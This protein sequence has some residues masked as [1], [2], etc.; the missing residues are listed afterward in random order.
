[1]ESSYAWL[2]NATRG[3]NTILGGTMGG[4]VNVL[5]AMMLI[6]HQRERNELGE[7]PVVWFRDSHPEDNKQRVEAKLSTR[8]H[9]ATGTSNI[10]YLLVSY[11]KSTMV[12]Q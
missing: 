1:M 5:Q 9:A 11:Q 3:M 7:I 4:Y 10:K 12:E 2:D 6:H 8:V